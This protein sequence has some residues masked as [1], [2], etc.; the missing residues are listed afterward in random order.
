MR[1]FAPSP[2]QRSSRSSPCVSCG[3]LTVLLRGGGSVVTMRLPHRESP[4]YP[5]EVEAT[6]QGFSLRAD[7][8]EEFFPS[9]TIKYSVGDGQLPKGESVCARCVG[10]VRIVGMA[11]DVSCDACSGWH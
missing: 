2:S 3:S 11:Q 6:I 9:T 4:R 8:D 1:L 5:F 10:G 7:G